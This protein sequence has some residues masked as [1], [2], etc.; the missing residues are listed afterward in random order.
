[1][2]E[3]VTP[4]DVETAKEAIIRRRDTHVDSLM[5]RLREPRVRRLVGPVIL[6]GEQPVS[7]NN[8]DWRFVTDL[9]LLRENVK[10][11]MV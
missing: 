2:L 1:M 9:G 11:R 3:S 5:E 4:A 8:E 6:G 7:R 10:I